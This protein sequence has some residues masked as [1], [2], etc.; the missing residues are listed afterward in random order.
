M[1][2]IAYRLTHEKLVEVQTEGGWDTLEELLEVLAATEDESLNDFID[3][4]EECIENLDTTEMTRTTVIVVTISH[5]RTF[6][7]TTEGW[8]DTDGN[9]FYYEVK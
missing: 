8:I 3:S 6:P 7:E 5:D 1:F 9:T 2:G 4:G